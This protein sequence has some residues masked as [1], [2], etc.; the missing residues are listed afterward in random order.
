MGIKTVQRGQYSTVGY[1]GTTSVQT[2]STLSNMSRSGEKS[3]LHFGPSARKAFF[4]AA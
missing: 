1:S 4:A 2:K 3:F